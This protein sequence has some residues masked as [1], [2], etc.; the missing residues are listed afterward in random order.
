MWKLLNLVIFK[1]GI[2]L[3][4]FV[5]TLKIRKS[6]NM[7]ISFEL[8]FMLT[9]YSGNTEMWKSGNIQMNIC[10]LTFMLTW[11]SGNMKI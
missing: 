10:L 4:T 3:L 11:Y 6:G 9:W 2:S 7:Q 8:T 5:L 1:R